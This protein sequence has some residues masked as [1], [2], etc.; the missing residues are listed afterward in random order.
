M[1]HLV[2]PAFDQSKTNCVALAVSGG[3]DS[4]AL[5]RLAVLARA[6][7]F[8][9]TALVAF[10]VDHGLREGSAAEAAKVAHM[11]AEH[12]ILHVTLRWHGGKP[13]TG[14]QAAARRARYDLM[15]DSCAAYGCAM[16]LT[17]HTA[18]DQAETVAMRMA[19][20]DSPK[21]LAGIW[22]VMTWNGVKVCRPLLHERREV[23]RA[24]LRD[25]DQPW[26]DDPSNE[27]VRFERVR[28]RKSLAAGDV[29]MFAARAEAAFAESVA[30]SAEA[31][32]WLEMH[33]RISKFGHVVFDR[34]SLSRLPLAVQYEILSSLF[35]TL[36]GA[37]PLREQLR[38]LVGQL[39]G[40]LPFRRTVAGGL[41]AART[42]DVIICREAGRI[43]PEVIVPA[44]GTV[45]WDGRFR[46]S[47]P[48]GT[49]VRPVGRKDAFAA[50]CC[51]SYV[52]AA[53]PRVHVAGNGPIL[54]HFQPSPGITVTL[55]ERFH[56]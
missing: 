5:L 42:H 24:F 28:I 46:I 2:I 1:P 49:V 29:P 36:G 44:G 12:D 38:V 55:G 40:A 30:N 13:G 23:L 18:D 6:D 56:L 39:R 47:A 21:S 25:I 35:K 4:V 20:T 50:L 19:R 3:S 45:L 9:S 22:P 34:A 41:I 54:P 52:V 32:T 33:Q 8:R 16:L 10:T 17:A 51:P 31:T 48:P 7:A 14:L 43:R 53:L 11:C 26:I 37:A 15:T 27:D